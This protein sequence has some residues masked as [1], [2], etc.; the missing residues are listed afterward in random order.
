M[1]LSFEM[2]STIATLRDRAK[3]PYELG[4]TCGQLLDSI[5]SLVASHLH[6]TADYHNKHPK[7]EID[8]ANFTAAIDIYLREQRTADG[9]TAAFDDTVIDRRK[10]KQRSKYRVK[11]IKMLEEAYKGV[12][13]REFKGIFLG[14]NT[15]SNKLFNKGIH[16]AMQNVYTWK[17]YPSVNVALEAGEGGDWSLWLQNRCEDLNR[18]L[19]LV[20]EYPFNEPNAEE[21]EKQIAQ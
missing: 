13:L 1:A 12:I 2:P 9:V 15:D 5:K 16:F 6:R 19:W 18:E 21:W 10:W 14:Y 3:E 17:K 20:E 7:A 4:L 11:Y 8:T